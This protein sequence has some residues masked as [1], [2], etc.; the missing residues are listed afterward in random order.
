MPPVLYYRAML[1]VLLKEHGLISGSE[2]TTDF[3][4]GRMTKKCSS[5]KDYVTFAAKKLNI[6][7]DIFVSIEDYR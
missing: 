6:S 2:D 7:P 1:Q 5:F 4:V 3:R